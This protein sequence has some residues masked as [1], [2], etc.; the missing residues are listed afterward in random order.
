V[1]IKIYHYPKWDLN[2]RALYNDVGAVRDIRISKQL[3]ELGVPVPVPI[4]ALVQRTAFIW[5]RCSLYAAKWLVGAVTMADLLK[6]I[7]RENA[8]DIKSIRPLVIAVGRFLGFLHSKGVRAKDMNTGNLLLRKS[9]SDK[10]EFFLIDYENVRL[11]KSLSLQIR[12]KNLSQIGVSLITLLK[13]YDR[14]LCQGYAQIVKDFD[15]DRMAMQVASL[16]VKREELKQKA[17]DR[18]F[19]QISKILRRNKAREI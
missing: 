2:F 9:G 4:A 10:Y 19:I 16:S 15:I 7:S 12:L 1:F 11:V 3:Q 17:L 18:R 6:D 5:P 13:D 8:S 14:V